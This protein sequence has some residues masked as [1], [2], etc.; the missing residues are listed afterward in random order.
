M[1]TEA[2]YY[3]W[4]DRTENPEVYEDMNSLYR[5]IYEDTNSLYQIYDWD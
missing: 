3:E 5:Q 2:E 4:L 1:P